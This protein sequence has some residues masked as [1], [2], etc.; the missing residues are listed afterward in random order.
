MDR[1]NVL[2]SMIV[3]AVS[4]NI[5]IEPVSEL[6]NAFKRQLD[7]PRMDDPNSTLFYVEQLSSTVCKINGMKVGE[8]DSC[9]LKFIKMYDDD[10]VLPVLSN[11]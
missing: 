2:K 4:F 3:A 5:N 1:R 9:G 7:Q 10:S 8:L 11:S 6:R